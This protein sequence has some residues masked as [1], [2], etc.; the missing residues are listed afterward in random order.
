MTF[1][2]YKT[3]EKH[4]TGIT[5]CNLQAEL[6]EMRNHFM[7]EKNDLESKVF[8][9][10]SLLIQ[11]QGSLKKREKEWDRLQQQLCKNV[12]DQQ[13]NQ[14][15][16][17]NISKPILKSFSQDKSASIRDAELAAAYQTIQNILVQKLEYI[18]NLFL[19]KK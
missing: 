4:S 19:I 11:V 13:K 6:R 15:S 10:H 5:I 18:N 12:K 3:Q 7:Q 9:S 14:K 8:Q 17:V 16:Q 1:P 2:K